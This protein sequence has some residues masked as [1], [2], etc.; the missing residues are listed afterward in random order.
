M[1]ELQER[2]P[3]LSQFER[4]EYQSFNAV[5]PIAVERFP[6]KPRMLTSRRR[7]GKSQELIS[8][9]DPSSV[10]SGQSGPNIM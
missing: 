4:H 10:N 2:S 8:H 6:Q 1:M 5:H 3:K 7:E 9:W